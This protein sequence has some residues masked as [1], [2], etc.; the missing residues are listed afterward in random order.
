MIKQALGVC[1]GFSALAYVG[2][3]MLP[4]DPCD[5]IENSAAPATLISKTANFMIEPWTDDRETKLKVALW[6]LKF[7]VAW[8]Q[9]VQRQFW[10][11][12][13]LKCPWTEAEV[14]VKLP[15][16]DSLPTP[17]GDLD[18]VNLPAPVKGG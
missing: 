2:F 12:D 13:N 9:Y 6:G 3:I 11:K 15:G 17:G 10:H 18:P 7:R 1:I 16:L 5:R 4:S 8:V 14:R